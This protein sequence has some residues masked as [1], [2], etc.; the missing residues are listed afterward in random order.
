MRRL[1]REGVEKMK[2]VFEHVAASGLL[3]AASVST[4]FAALQPD[5]APPPPAA[6]APAFE[7]GSGP[8][9]RASTQPAKDQRDSRVHVGGIMLSLPRY[10]APTQESPAAASPNAVSVPASPVR[11]DGAIEVPL[12]TLGFG[13]SLQHQRERESAANDYARAQA[14]LA[15]RQAEQ[16]IVTDAFGYPLRSGYYYGGGYGSYLNGYGGYRGGL[17]Q[18]LST[19]T[20]GFEDQ[21][22]GSALKN[23][24]DAA[25]TGT[26]AL[27][28]L[29]QDAIRNFGNAATPP[30]APSIEAQ[31]KAQRDIQKDTN[32]P[33]KP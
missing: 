13:E 12:N 28:N 14:D 4:S 6:P 2:N 26:G 31:Q 10:D 30:I 15:K 20:T 21:L 32:K 1:A 33:R 23:Y 19:H 24:S 9:V 5:Q 16:P 7:P 11:P 17:L 27:G 18:P 8:I 29:H 25:N 22:H 3:L